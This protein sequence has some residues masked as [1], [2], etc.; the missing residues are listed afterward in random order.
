MICL[1]RKFG[2]SV[3]CALVANPRHSG[4]REPGGFREV[5]VVGMRR[6]P[7]STLGFPREILMS[8]AVGLRKYAYVVRLLFKVTG[9]GTHRFFYFNSL[10]LSFCFVW[11]CFVSDGFIF[12]GLHTQIYFYKYEM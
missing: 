9:C 7:N 4:H 12:L 5:S 1:E 3:L 11:F 2:L 8:P 10:N 6:N